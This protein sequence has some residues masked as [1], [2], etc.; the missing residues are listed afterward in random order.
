MPTAAYRS[1]IQEPSWKK[2]LMDKLLS[3]LYNPE[4]IALWA[5]KDNLLCEHRIALGISANETVHSY[6]K[7]ETFSFIEGESQ[8]GHQHHYV[9][10]DPRFHKG[11]DIIKAEVDDL[12]NERVNVASFIRRMM[13]I[14]ATEGDVSLFLPNSLFNVANSI[15]TTSERTITED[16]ENKF[17]RENSIHVATIK[18]RMV[19]N[20]LLKR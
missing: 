20:L 12:L 1:V 6:Y 19:Q 3:K 13:N 8:V 7:G 10:L 17:A 11:M 4:R 18:Q 16:V 5:E 14:C 2:K 15:L 9:D